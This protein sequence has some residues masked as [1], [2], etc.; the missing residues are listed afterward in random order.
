MCS[1]YTHADAGRGTLKPAKKSAETA[2]AHGDELS[3]GE[4]M[5]AAAYRQ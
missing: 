1:V 3:V 2:P 4:A 5:A